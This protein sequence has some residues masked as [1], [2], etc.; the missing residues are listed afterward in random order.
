MT[1]MYI[2]NQMVD[3]GDI[4]ALVTFAIDDIK[5]FSS[6]NTSFSKTIV[7]PG[8]GRNN[9]VLGHIFD[10]RT[11]NAY[12]PDQDNEG[13]NFNAA[14]VADCIIFKD[15]IQVFKGIFRILEIVINNKI[16]EYECAVFGELSGL[17]SALGSSKIE[18]LDFSA[19]DLVYN[20]PNV[21]GSWNNTPGSGIYF[22]LIDFANT[23]SNKID[24]DILAFRP[25][26][27]VKEIIDKI[28]EAT[29]YTYESDLFSTDRFKELII[30]NNQKKLYNI[31]TIALELFKTGNTFTGTVAE[32]IA[33]ST[34]TIAGGFTGS[35]G[36]TLWTYAGSAIIGSI[37]MTIHVVAIT[38][39]SSPPY[40]FSILI[41]GVEV[42]QQL[43]V[44]DS[45]APGDI[46]TADFPV[47]IQNGD[48]LSV[49]VIPPPFGSPSLQI[50]TTFLRITNDSNQPVQVNY[51]ETIHV[52]GGLP[53]NI[54]QID[55]LSSLIKLFN[56]YVYDTPAD[57]KKLRITPYVDFYDTNVSGVVSWDYKLDRGREIRLKPM[58]EL[59]SRYYDFKFKQDGD[60]YNDQYQKNYNQGYGDY[61]F[62]SDFEFSN[63]KTDFEL[64]FAASPLVG[65]AGV[66]KIMT[67]IYKLSGTTEDEIASVI[68]IMQTKKITGVT[69]WALKNGVSTLATL[70]FYGYAGNYD[71][72]D[73][74]A[75]DIH[76]GVP[77]QLFF[78]LL[79]GAINVTQFNVYWSPYMAEITDK[80]SMLL[81]AFFKLT[82]NDI[83]SL[84]FSK[85]VYVNG[86]FWRL[87]KIE[88]WNAHSPDVT[89]CYLLKIINLIY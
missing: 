69:S 43:I 38:N 68:R 82:A 80:D 25:A 86:V 47:T 78:T 55:F 63:D 44:L 48:V 4:S 75:N 42:G 39:A 83:F 64:I 5:D 15:H 11:S 60:F 23:S 29:N 81:S 26:F 34:A 18:D 57:N 88:D 17:I 56:L 24:W 27:Y 13:I 74:P 62:D 21:C 51:N 61:T 70:T 52:N 66:D 30:P 3:V 37:A 58:S 87:N 53:Q 77:K 85:P 20:A 9:S 6:R 31:Q 84:D 14:V 33:W 79:S 76:F 22:P 16:P 40:E 59:N 65:Y 49:N 19:Y 35:S 2:E 46:T 12:D 41:N 1:E 10:V 36:N 54:K 72:P 28:F 73:A 71:D 45:P 7:M 67:A 32:L 8:T 89:K 50:G